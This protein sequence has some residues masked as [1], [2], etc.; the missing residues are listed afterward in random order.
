MRPALFFILCLSFLT[1]G[2]ARLE[3]SVCGTYRDL[4][5]EE[6]HLHRHTVARRQAAALVARDTQQAPLD[7]GEIAILDDSGGVVARR[8]P[9]NLDRKTLQFSPAAGSAAAYTFQVAAIDYDVDAAASGLPL[10]LGDDD[11][12]AVDLPFAFRFFG[13]SYR[14]IFVNSDGN[15]TFQAGDS[16][17]SSRSLGRMVAGL[18]RIAPLFTDLDPSQKSDGVRVLAEAARLVVS[19]VAVPAYSSSG[20]GTPQ[21]FQVRLY[22]DG[23]IEFAYNGIV[24]DGA[25]VGI[26]P[27]SMQG[28]GSVVSFLGDMSG[29]YSSTVAERFGGT[30]EVDVVTAAQRFYQTHDD[31]YDYLVIY[32]SEG[33]GACPGSIACEMTV[34]NHRSGYGDAQVEVGDQY[35]SA[36]RLQS[37]LNMGPLSEYPIDPNAAV[38][39]R[40]QTGDTPLSILGHETGHLFLAFASVPNPANPSVPPMLDSALA[41]WAFTFDS[42]ASF[43]QGNRI[44]DDGPE[45]SPRFT[46]TATVR[47]YS[48]L[49]QY[50]MG[51]RE[52]EEVPPVFLVNGPSRAFALQLPQVGVSF[53]GQRQ[54]IGVADIIAAEG[55]R[56]PDSTVSQRRFH[57]AFILIV[58]QGS[59]PSQAN[60]DQVDTYR[61]QFETY[62]SAAA[63]GRATA[64]TALRRGLKLSTFPAA[65]VF[66]GAT[67]AASLSIQSPAAA[68]LTFDLKTQTGAAGVDPSVTIPAGATSVDFNLTGVQA[69]VDEIDA[70]PDDPRYAMTV[71]RIQVLGGPDEAQ[72][73]VVS[74]D[75]ESVTWRVQDLNS[76]PYPGTPVQAGDSI[77]IADADGRVTVGAGVDVKIGVR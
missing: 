24:T 62:Y 57:F 59:A 67:I 1:P 30:D 29:Q 3:Q 11:S 61:R 44:R 47:E 43:M 39:G 18:P 7:A 73:V 12:D 14:R 64:D 2:F 65:G 27:G 52:P 38:P 36:G 25:V 13:A 41:H 45:A 34:R 35:G 70:Q 50:L 17:T 56:T 23:R 21:T 58:P 32:N 66:A 10:P 4:W 49:D 75:S 54:D 71:S 26:S 46:T 55:R 22:P 74:S 33:V 53:N 19:W 20:S 31:S 15:L 63:S 77:V 28:A 40:G 8:N 69:G 16:A 60:L 9:F 68:P 51:F 76:L 72:L 5:R 6:L 37:V 48:P 42:E